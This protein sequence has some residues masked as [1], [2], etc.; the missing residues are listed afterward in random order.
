M[1]HGGNV[2][3]GER[4]S[5]WLDF[6]ANLRPEGMPEWV[7][8]ALFR[9]AEDARYY[10]DPA[11]KAAR[12]GL[13]AYAGVNESMI[14][15]TAGGIEAID[16]A[17]S[18]NR[19]RVLT[20]GPTFGEYARRAEINGRACVNTDG[21]ETETGDTRVICNPNNPT[22]AALNREEI[23][24]LHDSL[25]ES[26]AELLVDE[27]FID[28]CPE[29]SVRGCVTRG[30]TVAGSLTKIL[31]VPGVRLGYICADEETVLRLSERALPWNLN[32]FA[33]KVASELPEHLGEIR[34]DALINV[35][36]REEFTELLKSIGADVAPSQ[37]N[38]LLCD[39]GRDM[40]DAVSYL[41]ARRILVRECASF[42]LGAN[43]LRLAVRTGDE[44]RLLTEELKKWLV[45]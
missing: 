23:L 4:P 34:Q 28:F 19:G 37:A 40:T 9:A 14:L 44:N 8:N 31:C 6:S 36:R 30:L 18:L 20:D 32:A 35:S 42:G 43:H 17:L 33:A 7:R 24:A 10:P 45:S 12:R 15:P 38:F 25:S 1:K 16:L 21:A 2:W 5:D 27:A 3:Q 22:G 39:F 13:A 26:G 11:M 41:K 29:N